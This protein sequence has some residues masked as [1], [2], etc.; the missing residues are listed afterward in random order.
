MALVRWDIS[1]FLADV[2]K[3]QRNIYKV[4]GQKLS[5]ALTKE[6][7]Q[8]V[9][10]T[11]QYSGNTA[12]SWSMGF[13]A[14]VVDAG[15]VKPKSRAEAFRK[16]SDPAVGESLA[17]NTLED[18]LHEYV[19]K[20]VTVTNGSPSFEFAEGGPLRPENEPG[21]M[22]SRFQNRVRNLHIT[23]SGEELER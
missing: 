11:P 12:A 1:K 13:Y 8:L 15:K 3:I 20:N 6:Y 9:T 4:P 5:A 17:R 14:P 2:K 10:E 19:R 22:F 18:N 23:V 7:E 21:G 16:G